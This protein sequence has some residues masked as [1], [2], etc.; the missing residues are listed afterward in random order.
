MAEVIRMPRMSD[1]MEE[2]NIVGWLKKEGDVIEPGETLA[3]VETDKATMELDSYVEGTLLH[4]AVK[5]GPVPIDGVIAVIGKPGE[6]WKTAISS[7]GDTAAA[8]AESAPEAAREEPAPQKT[9]APASNGVASTQD[10]KR[11][12]ASP[13]A[14]S[15]A[16]EAGIDISEVA[17]SGDHGRIVRRDVEAAIESQKTA[18]APAA[19]PAATP[20]PAPSKPAPAVTPFVYGGGEANYEEVAVSQMRKTIARRLSESK[21]S[22]PHFYLTIEINMDKAVQLRQK[23]NEVS[24]T[25][26]SFNDLVI[27]AAAAALRQHP[28]VNS[29]WLGDKIRRN[30]DINV[31]VAVAVEEGLLVPVIRYTDIKTLSQINTEVKVLAGKAKEK[32]LQPDEMQGNTF[33]ISNLGMFGIEEFTAIINPPDSCILAVGGI[34]EKPIVKDGQIAVGNMM[35]VTL[36]CDHR[37]VD[38][39]TGAQFLQTF[40]SI[41]EEPI[42][43]L[44]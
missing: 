34:I 40:K 13:L 27:K 36:S 12:K 32:K 28:A 14:K 17:G 4:I 3:E 5:E 29:S 33:T 31:G 37:V 24:P 2:G 30:K 39:A 35:K 38:G 15:M 18:P 44:V 19:Q 1:T 8:P 25:K 7:A 22:A 10:D 16:R 41:L 6:D 20:A 11:V 42:R 23:L 21:F 43:L 26:L 9:E